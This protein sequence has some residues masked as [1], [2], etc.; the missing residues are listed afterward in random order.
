MT[1]R[2]ANSLPESGQSAVR[3]R[4]E[5][6]VKTGLFCKMNSIAFG[7]WI[8]AKAIENTEESR[9]GSV[10][11]RGHGVTSGVGEADRGGEVQRLKWYVY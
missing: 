10:L 2:Q 7:I 1:F 6:L 11:R 8:E 4:C 9:S 5:Q 3:A